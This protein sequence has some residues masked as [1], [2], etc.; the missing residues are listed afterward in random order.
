MPVHERQGIAPP[1]GGA[2]VSPALLKPSEPPTT[3]NVDTSCD[4]MSSP[5]KAVP[6]PFSY[7]V[8]LNMA[9]KTPPEPRTQPD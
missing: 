6:G 2:P 3:A 5:L 1:Q 7:G 9:P 4:V 8:M